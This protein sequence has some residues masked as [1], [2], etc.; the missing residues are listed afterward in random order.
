M[1][2][3]VYERRRWEEEEDGMIII[4]R[5]WEWELREST[6]YKGVANLL[7]NHVNV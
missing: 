7:F 4:L 2:H 1:N 5:L 6:K 3:A